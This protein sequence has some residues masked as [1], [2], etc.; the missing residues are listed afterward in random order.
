VAVLA[1][2]LG[3]AGLGASVS[4]WLSPLLAFAGTFSEAI[5]DLSLL[6][7]IVLWDAVLAGV[8][9]A[10]Y[11]FWR[12]R[13]PK[14]PEGTGRGPA[15]VVVEGTGTVAAGTGGVAM[16]GEV[17]GDKPMVLP[18][19]RHELE[20]SL[21]SE[22][23]S[24]LPSEKP[25]P[26][27]E[28]VQFTVYRPRTVEPLLW[29]PL[30][31]F[32]HLEELP[33]DAAPGEPDPVTEV[34]EQARQVLGGLT[35]SYSD[36]TEDS[37]HAV[38]HESEITFLPEVPGVE[39]NP[40]R[41]TFLWEEAVHR[42]EFRMRAAASLDGQLARGRLSIFLGSILLAELTLRVKVERGST[43][44][45]TTLPAERDSI[46]PFRNIFASYSH[47]DDTVVEELERY[48][49]AMG[50]RYLRDVY[51]LRAGEY[52]NDRLMGLIRE[53]NV[54]QLFW[55]TNSMR[56][57]FV[58]QEWRYA[59][60]LQRQGFVRP[61][62]WEVPLPADPVRHLPPKELEEL[63]FQL[64]NIGA[65][66]RATPGGGRQRAA[67]KV[68]TPK[69]LPGGKPS[70]ANAPMA[71]GGRS[72]TAEA[73]PTSRKVLR[74]KVLAPLIALVGLI[75]GLAIPMS[76]LNR[77]KNAPLISTKPSL[78]PI[79][80]TPTLAGRPPPR[81]SSPEDISVPTMPLPLRPQNE[82]E[83]WVERAKSCGLDPARL[84]VIEVMKPLPPKGWVQIF[85]TSD[86]EKLEMVRK[87]LTSGGEDT[88]VLPR[89]GGNLCSIEKGPFASQVEA[90]REAQRISRTYGLHARATSFP[91]I[92]LLPSRSA[93]IRRGDFILP[94]P[95][96]REPVPLVVPPY[97]YPA[98]ARG[99]GLKVSVRVALLVN[100]DG[101][102]LDAILSERDSSQLG[103]NEIALD[104][105]K[106]M[107]FQPATRDDIP[108]RMW[109]ELI[110]DFAE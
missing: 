66:E 106:R 18:A 98:A 35:P 95:G 24:H 73:P 108:G 37:R 10:G 62:Y 89:E 33:P 29:Y 22:I 101:E 104:T 2:A 27:H 50:D 75:L 63:H 5:Q 3:L 69:S 54:F 42:E 23:R 58:E 31:V 87:R 11:R 60:S 51:D 1:V 15:P 17:Y 74:S 100:E 83:R 43:V 8:G 72:N 20:D 85:T 79:L 13:M 68:T 94:G 91:R 97:D 64:L 84:A 109:T 36:L 88:F 90:K 12:Q 41:R 76:W 56:S 57:T 40:S 4:W 61:T 47:R 14:A 39:F 6:D 46:S 9:L 77:P 45:R 93:E 86:R 105:A 82:R 34:E 92:P 30:L 53:A 70:S 96:V 19:A 80:T 52:W 102:V 65:G 7:H 32:A 67:Q 49:R 99:S 16:G 110:F 28:N 78:G 55:S 26:V 25:L 103:F 38:P 21:P 81:N 71:S 44:A 48:A 59:L 107:R